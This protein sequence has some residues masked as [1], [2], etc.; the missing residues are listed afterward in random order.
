MINVSRLY[1]GAAGAHDSLRYGH[2]A[3]GRAPGGE[4]R[5]VV[6][7]NCT[8]RCNLRCAHCYA[9]AEGDEA[10][11]DTRAAEAMLED[12]AAFGVPV[13]LLSGGEPMLRED[14]FGLIARAAGLGLRAVL[15]TNGTLIDEPAAARLAEAGTSYVGVSLDGIGE[16]HDRFR[17]E[18]GAFD[19][20]LAGLRHCRRAG[21]KTGVRFTLT[22][23]NAGQIE[24]VLG[25]LEAERIPRA[26]FYHLVYA[27]RG[28]D[29]RGEDLD[30][31]GARAAMD[32][33][34]ECTARLHGRG[35][36]GEILTVDN[37][38]D[39]PY[40]YLRMVREG[41][42]RAAEALRLLRANGGNA[43]GVGIGCVS[44]DGGVHPDQF[45]RHAALGNVRRRAFS[46]IWSDATI[47]LLRALRD[48]RAHLVGRCAGCRFLDACNGNLRVR[49]ESAG[50]LWGDDPACYLT[51]AE[52]A[53][54]EVLHDRT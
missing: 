30:A 50:D 22:R 35:F 25:L 32:C 42:E 52:I 36:A 3:A 2:G 23:R 6:V 4:R 49:A 38:A 37:H 41:S 24:A 28:A 5:P 21:L 47:P 45:W 12:L 8:A 39:G 27:G 44:W 7:W 53:P 16:V 46:A 26:C 31:P 29:L 54:V 51:D 14:L 34:L 18:A 33:I 13:L 43:S 48:R 20:A 1:C 10:E 17:G 9:A 15:S 40:L 11:M 19:R